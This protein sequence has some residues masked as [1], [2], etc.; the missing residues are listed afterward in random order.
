LAHPALRDRDGGA[1]REVLDMYPRE[2][3]KPSDAPKSAEKIE[4][5]ARRMAVPTNPEKTNEFCL[6]PG[7]A[8]F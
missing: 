8:F 4:R 5:N 3:R 7:I 2:R 6:T 1:R